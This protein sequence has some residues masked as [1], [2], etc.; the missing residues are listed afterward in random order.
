MAAQF[1]MLI[2]CLVMFIRKTRWVDTGWVNGV[3]DGGKMH[4]LMIDC[5]ISNAVRSTYT[6][7]LC[8]LGV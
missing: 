8:I 7:P 6:N 1:D 5:F 2:L 4:I 3:T